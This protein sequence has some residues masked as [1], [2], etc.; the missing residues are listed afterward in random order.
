MVWYSHWAGSLDCATDAVAMVGEA[1]DL[2][3]ANV[4][5]KRAAQ[6]KKTAVDRGVCV[7]RILLRRREKHLA[8][9]NSLLPCI[10]GGGFVGS[11]L[12]E[13]GSETHGRNRLLKTDRHQRHKARCAVCR[14]GTASISSVGL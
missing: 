7:T 9:L 5:T 6:N 4:I 2:F 13:N 3:N 1:S 11:S 14:N 10:S 8:A 12:V